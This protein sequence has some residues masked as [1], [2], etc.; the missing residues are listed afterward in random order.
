MKMTK[1]SISPIELIPIVSKERKNTRLDRISE[2]LGRDKAA[3]LMMEFAGQPLYFP[4]RTTLWRFAKPLIIRRELRYIQKDTPEFR[5]KI[6][7]LSRVL[8]TSKSSII[9]MYESGRY[10]D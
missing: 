5:K 7:E 2:L 6:R 10:S 3:A 4:R 1:Y 8:K 9:R